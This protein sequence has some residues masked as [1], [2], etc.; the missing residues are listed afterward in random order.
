MKTIEKVHIIPLGFER[1]IVV[2]P[3]RALGGVR[4]HIVTI[5]GKFAS[6]YEMS[7]K[8]R[9]FE[10]AVVND[11]E[12][13]GID[14]EVHYTDLFDF[15]MTIG[16]ISKII[17][18]EKEGGSEVYVNI[19]SHGRLVSVASAL[20]SWY[21]CAKAYYVLPDGYAKNDREEKQFGRSICG[22]HPRILEIPPIWIF[23]LPDEEKHALS[24]IY[25]KK[26]EGVELVGLS[27]IIKELQ[28][29]FPDIYPP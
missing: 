1:S 15:K 13:I 23:K 16:E 12:N 21:H 4:A 24:F 6:K 19:S 22:K 25:S 7:E 11:L 27:E 18:T 14:V 3:V 28:R 26:S 29:A 9:Y 5:G 10:R 8:Q 20:A 17:L 2:N